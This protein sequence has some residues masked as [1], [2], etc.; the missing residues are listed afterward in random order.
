MYSMTQKG[1][2]ETQMK[3]KNLNDASTTHSVCLV[4]D[5]SDM[6]QLIDT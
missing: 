4:M 6:F 1:S 3:L 5:K 2:T